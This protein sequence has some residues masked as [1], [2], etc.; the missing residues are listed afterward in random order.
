MSKQAN[1]KNIVLIATMGLSPAVL[2]ETVWALAHAKKPVIPDEIVVLSAK[3]SVDKMKRDLLEGSDPVWGRLLFALKKD[4]IDIDGKLIFGS[5]SI[6]VIPDAR[7][8]EMWDLRSSEDNLLAADF[9]M[10]E[11][12]KYSESPDTE[13]IASIAGGRKTMSALLLSC[14]TLLGREED[15]VVHVL[16]PE[17]LEGGAEP[18]FYFPQKGIVH[19]SKRTGKKYKGDKLESELFEVPFVRMRGW[20]QEK[21]KTNPPTYFCA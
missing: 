4:K 3:N 5:M 17:E 15:R 16:L 8:N 7:K 6:H 21:F 12:R 20:Y 13:I 14:M 18:P 11:I 2:T 19:V 10:Q 9:M 1:D